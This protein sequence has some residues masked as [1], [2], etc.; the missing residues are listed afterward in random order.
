MSNFTFLAPGILSIF[1]S[2]SAASKLFNFNKSEITGILGSAAYLSPVSPFETFRRGFSMKDCIMGWGG[3]TG[4]LSAKMRHFEFEGADT[5]IE[6]DFGFARVAAKNYDFNRGLSGLGEDFMILNTGIKP[7]ACC[8][9]HH[10]AIDATLKIRQKYNPDVRNIE[11]IIDRT[12][13]VSSRGNNPI[14]K[15]IAEAKYSNPYIIAIVLLEG[16]ANREQ[17]TF[18]KIHNGDI[19]SLAEKV[20][21]VAD[22]EL[23]KLYDEKWPS[24][25]EIRM[26]D[27]NVFTARQDIPKGEPEYPVTDQ[28]L[29]EKFISLSTDTISFEKA[30]KIWEIVMNIEKLDTIFKLS[31]LLCK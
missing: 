23:D 24:I 6:G 14:P 22:P 27:G 10:A 11:K 25:V 20:E 28:E 16:K 7:Y 5:G 4:I 8:R 31:N 19:L 29:K 17:F 9:Q 30:E 2:A 13:S 26:N 15:T 21:V 12:F 1:S 3:L 18:E